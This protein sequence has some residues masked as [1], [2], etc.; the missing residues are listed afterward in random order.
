[1]SD[2]IEVKLTGMDSLLAELRNLPASIRE[3]VLIG[4]VAKAATVIKD[5]AV[6][7]APEWHG[8]VAKGHPPPGTLKR[9]IYSARLMDQCTDTFEARIVSVRSGKFYSAVKVKG[10]GTVNKDAFY[11]RW[12]EYGHYTRTPG[13][14]KQQ[15]AKARGGVDLYTGAKWVPPRPFL[16]PAFD[17]KKGEAGDAMREYLR[18][19]LPAALMANKMLKVLA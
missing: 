18:A 5:E 2:G 1:M 12:V 9:A 14:T 6:R 10:G 7:L 19:N 15:H 13:M 4:A 17:T 11:A 16:R 3:R 8:T